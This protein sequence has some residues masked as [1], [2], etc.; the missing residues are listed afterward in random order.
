MQTLHG[1]GVCFFNTSLR[2]KI[3]GHF[4]RKINTKKCKCFSTHRR[5]I[6]L[7]LRILKIAEAGCQGPISCSYMLLKVKCCDKPAHHLQFTLCKELW[8][9]AP[10]QWVSERRFSL[11]VWLLIGQ[12]AG[13]SEAFRYRLSTVVSL[14]GATH[15]TAV[16]IMSVL[17]WAIRCRFSKLDQ[18]V[19]FSFFLT[20]VVNMRHTPTH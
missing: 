12:F 5:E 4:Q 1:E 14:I 11:K 16:A 2:L 20:T 18:Y 3:R 17:L 10:W 9:V 13:L 6:I 15:A 8:S 19:G 7:K